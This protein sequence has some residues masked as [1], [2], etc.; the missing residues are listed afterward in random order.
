MSDKVSPPSSDKS[1]SARGSPEVTPLHDAEHWARLQEENDD[2]DSSLGT[3]TES[4]TASMTSSIVNYRTIHGRT[5]HSDRGNAQYW[6]SNDTQQVEAMDIIEID[7]CTQE[8]TFAPDSFDFVH[9]RYLYGSIGDWSA[10]FKEAY[11]ACKPGG[12]VESFEASPRMESDD[13]TVTERCA[14]NEW[15][16]FFIE[17]GRKLGRP[18]TIIDEDLQQRYMEEA[19]F[20]PIGSWPKDPKLKEIGQFSHAAMEQDFEGFVLYMAS[21]VLGWSKEEVSVYCSQLRREMRS[22]KYHPYCRLRVVYGRKPEK[23]AE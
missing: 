8:W 1:R 11:R 7:D 19:G 12:W 6:A 4:S 15:G 14:I 5:Y 18:F 16:K 17:G 13:G 10:L 3:D 23:P 22:G 21:I 20:A 9:M 2:A